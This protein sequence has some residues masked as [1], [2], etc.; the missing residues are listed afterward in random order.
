MRIVMRMHGKQLLPFSLLFLLAATAAAA[1]ALTPG[2]AGQDQGAAP[3]ARPPQKL[4]EG[5]G[6]PAFGKITAI[7]KGSLELAKPDGSTLTVKFTDKT[8]Y[9][10]DRQEAKLADFKVG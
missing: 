5:R 1:K 6:Q 9:R 2:A 8:E 7:N 10:R 4:E 3:T